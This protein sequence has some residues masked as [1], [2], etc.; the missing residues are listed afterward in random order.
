MPSALHLF[1]ALLDRSIDQIA[2]VSAD[3]RQ[4]DA[5]LIRDVA[6]VWDNNTHPFVASATAGGRRPLRLGGRL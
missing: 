3:A 6:D 4:F 2:Q 1:A 5:A